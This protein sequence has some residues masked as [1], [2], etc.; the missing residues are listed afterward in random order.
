MPRKLATRA[1]QRAAC[2]FGGFLLTKCRCNGQRLL[3]T[4][5][6]GY[7]FNGYWLFDLQNVAATGNDSYQPRSG[8]TKRGNRIVP[9]N[10]FN[11]FGLAFQ[12]CTP[13]LGL[14][15]PK[16]RRS[17]ATEQARSLSRFRVLSVPLLRNGCTTKPLG[18]ATEWR[19]TRFEPL[20]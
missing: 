1:V 7:S 9:T 13:Y 4:K 8:Y 20:F 3:P 2:F 10:M 17:A 16:H 18:V 12:P 11:R 6:S 19:P 5:T 15:W 14:Q